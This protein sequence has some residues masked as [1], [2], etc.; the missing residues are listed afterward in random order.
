MTPDDSR[1][2]AIATRW[3]LIRAAHAA[4]RAQDADA[5]RRALVLRY[6]RAV[7]RYVG[8][9]VRNAEDADELAQEVVVRLLRGDFGGADPDR[10][11]FRDLLKTAVRNMVHN[12]W[13]KANR[14]RPAGVDPD[15]LPGAADRP[16]DDWDAA[17]RQNVLDHTWAALQDHERAHP[18]SLTYTVLKLRADFPDET[19][20]QLAARVSAKTGTRVRPDACR[21]M[22]RRARVRFAELLVREVE[23]GLADPSPDRVAEDLAALGLLE[24]VRDFLPPDWSTSGK[25]SEGRA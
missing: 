9:I 19:S 15:A 2:D 16:D 23:L 20:D 13:A 7:R 4:G 22:V 8:G 24:Y 21:Q 5:A 3:S 12:H 1:L 17:W 6:A 18:G 14:R 11:R 25:L 10:G